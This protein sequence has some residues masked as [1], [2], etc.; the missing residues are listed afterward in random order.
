MAGSILDR[1]EI[2]RFGNPLL[3]TLRQLD[4]LLGEWRAVTDA[5]DMPKFAAVERAAR[6]FI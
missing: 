3:A 4:T 5:G 1:A 6:Q 2:D